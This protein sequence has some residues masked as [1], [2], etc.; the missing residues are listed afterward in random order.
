MG[1]PTYSVAAI[2]AYLND[3]SAPELAGLTTEVLL[4]ILQDR[5]RG[6]EDK[7]LAVALRF[8]DSLRR[9]LVVQTDN[10][11]MLKDTEW[12]LQNVKQCR[13]LLLTVLEP[14]PEGLPDDP[15]TQVETTTKTTLP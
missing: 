13:Q 2:P 14:L 3:L 12:S 1:F 8:Q 4:V 6:T 9:A 10:F 15:P 7:L 5:H 11:E